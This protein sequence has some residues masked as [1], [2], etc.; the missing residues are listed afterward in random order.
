MK[1]QY[2]KLTSNI[3]KASASSVTVLGKNGGLLLLFI[4]I[5]FTSVALAAFSSSAFV[6][7]ST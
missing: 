7:F 3:V 4:V 1:S 2:D 6:L 5:S